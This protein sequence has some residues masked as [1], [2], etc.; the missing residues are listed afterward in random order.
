MNRVYVDESAVAMAI[1]KILNME[2]KITRNSVYVQGSF[3]GNST[4]CKA[5]IENILTG[6]EDSGLLTSASKKS[7]SSTA[8][9][10]EISE[11]GW[12]GL[13][14]IRTS[15]AEWLV[16]AEDLV[17][18]YGSG[19]GVP[20]ELFLEKAATKQAHRAWFQKVYLPWLQ[21]DNYWLLDVDCPEGYSVNRQGYKKKLIPSCGFH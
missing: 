15:K 13:Q 5:Q 10:Y 18:S 20:W 2:G 4:S 17:E 14:K 11:S 9:Y 1:S 21:N 12:A 8:T 3:R 7:G 6:W 19:L 16:E